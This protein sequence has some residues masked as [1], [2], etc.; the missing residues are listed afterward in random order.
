MIL[1][2]TLL[3]S[4]NIIFLNYLNNYHERWEN[5]LLVDSS[6]DLSV[7]INQ[8]LLFYLT[9][10]NSIKIELTN[11]SYSVFT[12]VP[13][14]ILSVEYQ[15]T[16]FQEFNFVVANEEFLDGFNISLNYNQV[17][18]AAIYEGYT[19]LD[20]FYIT[21]N[22]YLL[23]VSFSIK[24]F[25]NQTHIKD[26]FLGKEDLA[27]ILPCDNSIIVSEMSFFDIINQFA[28][29]NIEDITNDT[30]S[31]SLYNFEFH[32]EDF[33]YLTPLKAYK[34]SK[35]TSLSIHSCFHSV[36]IP[37]FSSPDILSIVFHDLLLSEILQLAKL[38]TT[39]FIISSVIFALITL[40]FIYAYN[41]FLVGQ[42]RKFEETSFLLQS[43]G[44]K[45]RYLVK[46]S[47]GIK[48]TI[49]LIASIISLI[50]IFFFFL[51]QG[52]YKWSYSYF[53][54]VISYSLVLLPMIIFQIKTH[55]REK[56]TLL[57]K[58]IHAKPKKSKSEFFS[59]FFQIILI[60]ISCGLL[61]SIWL[62]YQKL[63]G[64]SILLNQSIIFA[65]LTIIILVIST[66]FI[67]INLVKITS[68][69]FKRILQYLK[70]PHQYLMKFL[71]FIHTNNKNLFSII[72][73]FIFLN[74]FIIIS[75]DLSKT[76]Y[77]INNISS[78][79]YDVSVAFP[80]EYSD[81]V[82]SVLN[83]NDFLISYVDLEY[84]TYLFPIFLVYLTDPLKYYEGVNFSKESFKKHK[85]QEIFHILNSSENFVISS[86]SEVKE[87]YLEIGDEIYL[88]KTSVNSTVF[89]EE[90]ILLDYTRYLPFFSKL[91]G[92]QNFYLM[93]YDKEKD[94]PTKFRS[95]II[96][97]SN[98]DSTSL[99]NILNFFGEYEI[100]YRIIH[101][102][103]ISDIRNSFEESE[104]YSYFKFILLLEVFVT[105]FLVFLMYNIRIRA[106]QEAKTIIQRGIKKQRL[107]VI[108][109]FWI[110][111]VLIFAL[112][113]SLIIS[114]VISR[115]I[116]FI[117]N[118]FSLF[119]AKISLSYISFIIP[120]GM[121]IMII[122]LTIIPYYIYN[123]GIKYFK[124][125]NMSDRKWVSK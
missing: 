96:S 43:R 19:D 20:N 36:Y 69:F 109:D 59:R 52:I 123:K 114:L 58:Q 75:F 21:V 98:E 115:L 112:L 76:N 66:S 89:T 25:I 70:L 54:A 57:D 88:S 74:T 34:K 120:L 94:I 38:M 33:I 85:N 110:S 97:F 13:S 11:H 65:V 53:V 104:I 48:L 124:N 30:D 23:N 113:L 86:K 108:L 3:I 40:I 67:F 37:Y 92:N 122:L 28:L 46:L 82:I 79:C 26:Y 103:S 4:S 44:F 29:E 119:Q 7:E 106:I 32:E 15:N 116:I 99:T 27:D 24:G 111:L 8:P 102:V 91:L 121:F 68:F 42:Q 49:N 71:K 39:T 56:N 14:Q 12:R 87:R 17:I 41:Q 72:F 2:T 107:L 84:T 63:I 100:K 81:D 125:L 45:L 95:S 83:T 73:I 31:T 51:N 118:S 1:L 90:K 80:S 117:Y 16:S 62:S 64:E 61:I 60:I 47:L 77:E 10:K 78:Y 18:F 93:K 101:Q 50:M 22:P 105:F 6:P 9:T 35:E 55:L 5:T